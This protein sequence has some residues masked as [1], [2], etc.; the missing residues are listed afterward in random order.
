MDLCQK[1][2]DVVLMNPPFGS[3][4]LLAEDYL[5]KA[6]PNARYESYG[7]FLI[8]AMELSDGSVGALTSRGFLFLANYQSI[9]EAALPHLSTFLDLGAGVLDGAFVEVCASD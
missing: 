2:Y 5:S 1:R 6:Y 3:P 9:R 4:S 8:R 7:Q